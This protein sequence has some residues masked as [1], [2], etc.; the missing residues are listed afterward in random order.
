MIALASQPARAAGP[1]YV[2]SGGSDSNTCLSPATRCATINGA[3]NKPG[4]MAGDTIRVATGTYI[5]TGSEVVLLGKN[6]TLSGGWDAGFTAQS[7][8]SIVDG[9]GSRR[10]ITVS[11]GVTAIIEHFT[12]QSGAATSPS[13]LYWS[14]GGGI[15]NGGTLT[16]NNSIVSDNT[17]SHFGGG[18]YNGGTLTLNNSTVSGNTNTGGMA[19][20]GGGGIYNGYYRTLTLNSSTVAGNTCNPN[21]PTFPSCSG[22]GIYNAQG[23][24]ALNNSQSAITRHRWGGHH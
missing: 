23:T 16:L 15:Y 11:D 4:F 19:G 10:G 1:W 12:V 18:I 20:D 6:A 2:G 8:S 3:L 5:N 24:L 22:G 7:G 21:A 14:S 9:Q 17:V 13:Y